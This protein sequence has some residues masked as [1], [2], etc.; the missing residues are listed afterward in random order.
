MAVKYQIFIS[1]TYD[2]LRNE[3]EQVVKTTLEMG[4]IPVGME[5]FS[6]ADEEQWKIITRHIDECDYYVVIVAQRYGSVLEGISYTEKE[7]NYA[8]SKDIP[9]LAFIINDNTPWPTDLVDTNPDQKSSLEAFKTK[10]KRKPVSFWSSAADLSGKF[11]IALG[12]QITL[13]P[14][15]GWQRTTDVVN[16][17][18][19]NELSRLSSENAELRKQLQEAR[20]QAEDEE[21]A[22]R[23]KIRQMMQKNTLEISFYYQDGV[24]WE[25]ETKITLYIIFHLLAP[26]MM[27]EETTEDI[28]EYIG[29]SLRPNQDRRLRKNYP[30]PQN[31][32]RHCISD[33]IALGLFEPSQKRHTVSDTNE[34][35][36]LT[37]LG[38][39]VY[40][41]IRR[42]KL[43]KGESES[44]STGSEASESDESQ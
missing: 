3:R 20:H 29:L 25:D 34:Y 9:V 5:M 30:V 35:W 28:G 13:T 16:P 1:S 11:S 42:S 26:E 7:Y 40:T 4:H 15:P 22:E 41:D 38:R 21:I 36:T 24:D 2:D 33:F 37:N 6:A 14:R 32:V 31:V 10:L 12:K 18:V 17:D 39:A 27:I 43:E 23:R 19:T 8:V 44:T